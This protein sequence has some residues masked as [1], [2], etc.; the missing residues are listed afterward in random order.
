MSASPCTPG[1]LGIGDCPGV[2]RICVRPGSVLAKDIALYTNPGGTLIGWPDGMTANLI[3]KSGG[4]TGSYPITVDG[5]YL[6]I[7]VSGANT[8]QWPKNAK[9]SI[10]LLFDGY[11]SPVTWV[12]GDIDRGC[13]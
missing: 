7:L 10:Q 4:F 13:C 5:P 1:V 2:L 12:E 11:D 6:R 8:V 3:I 9:A